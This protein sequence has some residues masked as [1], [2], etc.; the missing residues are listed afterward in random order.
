[1]IEL[2]YLPAIP[3]YIKTSKAFK[4]PKGEL[5]CNSQAWPKRSA[6]TAASCQ[7]YSHCNSSI[8][9]AFLCWDTRGGR[10]LGRTHSTTVCH[11]ETKKPRLV[12]RS[13][14]LLPP[15]T[16]IDIHFKSSTLDSHCPTE[17]WQKKGIKSNLTMLVKKDCAVL[18][19]SR[20]SEAHQTKKQL[21]T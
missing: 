3:E 20:D 11:L 13:Q 19:L 10:K 17:K 2:L 12:C 14:D 21:R 9:Q 6:C 1:M 15:C 7:L 5:A 8:P 18:N 16:A 4:P